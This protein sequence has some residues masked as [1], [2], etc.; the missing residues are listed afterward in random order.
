MVCSWWVSVVLYA[1]PISDAQRRFEVKLGTP[2]HLGRLC[3]DTVNHMAG[4]LIS[5]GH[6]DAATMTRRVEG[7]APNEA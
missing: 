3:V 2:G 4:R 5:S 1:H 7:W 6:S